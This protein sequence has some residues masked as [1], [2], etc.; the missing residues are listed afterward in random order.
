MAPHSGRWVRKKGLKRAASNSIFLHTLE[1]DMDDNELKNSLNHISN[2][3]LLPW[4]CLIWSTSPIGDFFSYT[5]QLSRHLFWKEADMNGKSRSHIHK[6]SEVLIVLKKD[7]R[8][9]LQT[10]GTV[11][12]ILTNSSFHPHGIK[13]R[14]TSG[15]VGR[16]KDIVTEDHNW[17][18][19]AKSSDDKTYL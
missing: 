6:G 14:L 13:V 7:Q 9:G 11:Q 19:S 10:R 4:R 17:S 16:V 8:S 15:L 18:K 5:Q 12:D 2:S 1:T 3:L